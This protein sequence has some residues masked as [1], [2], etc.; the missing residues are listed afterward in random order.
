MFSNPK[1]GSSTSYEAWKEEKQSKVER[2]RNKD[3]SEMVEEQKNTT[4]G[5]NKFLRLDL[6]SS[7]RRENFKFNINTIT[8]SSIGRLRGDTG[9]V[10]DAVQEGG[11]VV[12]GENKEVTVQN[13]TERHAGLG[14]QINSDDHAAAT[15]GKTGQ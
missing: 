8:C 11:G 2:K 9:G 10:G 12:R 14:E 5:R 3:Q 4:A 1:E 6:S 13:I 7:E 15:S